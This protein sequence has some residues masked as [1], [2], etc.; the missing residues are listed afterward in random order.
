MNFNVL[1]GFQI[2]HCL[3]QGTGLENENNKNKKTLLALGT[4]LDS[5]NQCPCPISLRPPPPPPVQVILLLSIRTEGCQDL[6]LP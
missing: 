3:S 5:V 2:N 1:K 4:L 6:E